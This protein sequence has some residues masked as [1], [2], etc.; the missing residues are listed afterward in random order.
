M[1]GLLATIREFFRFLLGRR[2]ADPNCE[3]HRS[4]YRCSACRG[5]IYGFPVSTNPRGLPICGDCKFKSLR[6]R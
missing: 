5:M 3:K 1:R 6:K 2:P 4:F